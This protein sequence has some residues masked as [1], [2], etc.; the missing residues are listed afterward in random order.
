M[1]R[2]FL[3]ASITLAFATNAQQP[4]ND[5]YAKQSIRYTSSITV[6]QNPQKAISVVKHAEDLLQFDSYDELV[7]SFGENNITKDNYYF[8]TDEMSPCSVL[9]P[10][11]SRQA[12]FIWADSQAQKTLQYVV[13]GGSLQ[14]TNAGSNC[15]WQLKNAIR[16]GMSIAELRELNGA[17]FR[18]YGGA[19]AYTGF[20]MPDNKG[21]IN[22]NG[23]GIAL[24]ADNSNK[25][26]DTKETLSADEAIKAG[27]KLK[28]YTIILYPTK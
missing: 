25:E 18:F 1:K 4:Y 14:N 20:I 24:A 17:N 6:Y 26:I 8:S 16:P 27:M 22:F 9:Y 2:I 5:S 10:G 23:N 21:A 19:T 7:K 3:A 11:T 28:V 13:L 12:I 15:E